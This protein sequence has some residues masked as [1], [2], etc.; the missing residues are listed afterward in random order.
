MQRTYV[1]QFGRIIT[2]QIT[3]ADIFYNLA[4]SVLP[5]VGICAILLFLA[6]LIYAF[7]QS[8]TNRPK[9]LY[10]YTSLNIVS[11]WIIS[12]LYYINPVVLL[13]A[14]IYFITHVGRKDD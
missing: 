8:F 3:I 5:I 11:C 2:E 13:A 9:E 1:D 6:V 7:T 12:I 10:E 14:G 4:M